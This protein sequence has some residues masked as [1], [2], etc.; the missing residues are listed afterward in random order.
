MKK[1]VVTMQ[2]QTFSVN[3]HDQSVDA[4]TQTPSEKKKQRRGATGI[5]GFVHWSQEE[6][7]KAFFTWLPCELHGVPG[8]DW[9]QFP[10]EVMGYCVRTIGDNPDSAVLAVAC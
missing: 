7:R 4:Q 1:D 10:A 3:G 2:Y 6:Q 8:I 5:R 9:E